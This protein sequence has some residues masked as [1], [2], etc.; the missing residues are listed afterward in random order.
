MTRY[1]LPIGCASSR[2]LIAPP[3]FVRNLL[4][5]DRRRAELTEPGAEELSPFQPIRSIQRAQPLRGDHELA[6][7]PRHDSALCEEAQILVD[8]FPRRS[9]EHAQLALRRG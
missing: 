3:H 6:P 4:Q 5:T 2:V 8:A 7:P 9:D 1:G